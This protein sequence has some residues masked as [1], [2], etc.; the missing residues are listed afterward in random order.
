MGIRDLT[1]RLL[2]KRAADLLWHGVQRLAYA[3]DLSPA[4]I[5]VW[6]AV[7][8]YT[9]TTPERVAALMDAVRYVCAN[10]IPGA[11]VE[12]GVWRGGSMM[13]VALSLKQLGKM[14]R[15]LV[16]FDTFRSAGR[17]SRIARVF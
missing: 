13:A 5:S 2:P 7:E 11:L 12:C 15:D 8:R 17:P 16:L 10:G 6:R 9:M 14:D 1:Q 4:E 3:P